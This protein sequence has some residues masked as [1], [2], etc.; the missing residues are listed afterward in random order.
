MTD[1]DVALAKKQLARELK[2][3][4]IVQVVS[5][6]VLGFGW[7]LFERGETF[8]KFHP[9]HECVTT[10]FL[11]FLGF[12]LCICGFAV[13]VVVAIW[14]GLKLILFFL[15]QFFIARWLANEPKEDIMNAE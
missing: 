14:G 12:L 15:F 13:F 4:T 3:L 7:F 6:C 10:H 5:L 1:F 11:H 8:T 2:I 9:H